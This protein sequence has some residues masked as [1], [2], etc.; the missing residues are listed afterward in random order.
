MVTWW[1]VPPLWEGKTVAILASG[2]SLTPAVVASAA[3]LPRIVVNDSFR[4]APDAELLYAAD[5]SWWT[6]NNDALDFVGLKVTI[7][8]DNPWPQVHRL[9]NT[10]T[11]GFDPDPSSVRTGGNSGYQAL[12]LA[13]QGQA[14]RILLCGY[15]M[16]IN[17]GYH[18]FGKHKF[19]LVNTHADDFPARAKRFVLLAE[20]AKERGIEII[21]CSLG[22]A[23]DAFPIRRIEE[24]LK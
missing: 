23:I 17:S 6:I 19:P 14:A 18:W 4:L 15:D 16:H 20:A 8:T 9:R 7:G 24:L 21:N 5:T 1:T 10:G 12:H 2:P 13:I 3:V 11:L 22:S